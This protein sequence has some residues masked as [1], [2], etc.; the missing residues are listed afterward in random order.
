MTSNFDAT[1]MTDD[2]TGIAS[3]SDVM[4]ANEADFVDAYEWGSHRDD[5]FLDYLEKVEGELFVK[6]QVVIKM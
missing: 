6:Y 1:S 4:N 3:V 2:T 5:A